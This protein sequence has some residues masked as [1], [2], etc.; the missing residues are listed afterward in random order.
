M[1]NTVSDLA[2]L[3]EQSEGNDPGR[4]RSDD[5]NPSVD[6]SEREFGPSGIAL[7]SYRF[8]T[9]WFIVGFASDLAAGQVKRMHYFGQ[10][11]VMFR[12]ESGAVNVLD[13]YC[14]HLGANMGVG[15]TVEGNTS[16]ARGTAGN[17]GATAPM[18]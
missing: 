4:G 18:R 9:G 14:L 13:A 17:G 15:G 6:P 5:P 10:E 1:T 12:T 8:P 3:G 2:H 7:S 16:S 11:L